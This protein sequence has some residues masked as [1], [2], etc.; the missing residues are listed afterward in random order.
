MY[1]SEKKKN[2]GHSSTKS[3]T[4]L[5]TKMEKCIIAQSLQVHTALHGHGYGVTAYL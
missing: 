3:L 1:G 5:R 4:K 2:R